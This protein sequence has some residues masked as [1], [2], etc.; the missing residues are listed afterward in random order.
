MSEQETVE[1]IQ[2]ELKALKSKHEAL[3]KKYRY[4]WHSGTHTFDI[5]DEIESVRKRKVE[6]EDALKVMEEFK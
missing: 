6:L 1:R 2:T 5:L 3:D 4:T